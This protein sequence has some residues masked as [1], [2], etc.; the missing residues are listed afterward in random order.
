MAMHVRA[1]LTE[2][3]AYP[4]RGIFRYFKDGLLHNLSQAESKFV[5]ETKSDIMYA[6]FWLL[7]F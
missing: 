4:L 5:R 7:L 6:I 1:S 2:G 3:L